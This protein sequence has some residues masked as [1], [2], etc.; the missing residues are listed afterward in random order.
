M[1]V[2]PWARLALTEAELVGHVG[3]P[4]FDAAAACFGG[5]FDTIK[6][7]RVEAARLPQRPCPR[8]RAPYREAVMTSPPRLVRINYYDLT[9]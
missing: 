6:L 7:R 3:R 9:T 2:S 4:A 8:A 1:T 5:A